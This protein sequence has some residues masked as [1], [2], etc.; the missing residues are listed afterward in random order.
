MDGFVS[1]LGELVGAAFGGF[2]A[3]RAECRARKRRHLRGQSGRPAAPLEV[4]ADRSLRR[5]LVVPV[6]QDVSRLT[7]QCL[8][9]SLQSGEPDRPGFPVLQNGEICHR[10]PNL[11]RELGDAHFP[12]GQHHVD[13]DYRGHERDLIPSSHFLILYLR[14]FVEVSEK[15]QLL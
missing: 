14:H 1:V 12:L 6:F 11:V 3:N 2:K 5:L 15:R 8:A 9:D 7:V 13:I 4:G 10:D